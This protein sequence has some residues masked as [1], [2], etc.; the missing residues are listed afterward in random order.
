MPAQGVHVVAPPI[1]TVVST[2][3][4]AKRV[5]LQRVQAILQLFEPS[6][7]ALA[8]KV[9]EH[10]AANEPLAYDME[11]AME[12]V[13]EIIVQRGGRLATLPTKAF[14]SN[15]SLLRFDNGGEGLFLRTST[16][17]S[18]KRLQRVGIGSVRR[19]ST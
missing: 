8:W 15:C 17:T 3:T 18:R 19:T 11:R 16:P 13:R 2:Q 6:R 10:D 5:A 9:S 14:L 7:R 12:R 4:D 1:I